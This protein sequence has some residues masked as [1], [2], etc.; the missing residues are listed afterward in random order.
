MEA[1]SSRMVFLV[2]FVLSCRLGPAELKVRLTH[3]LKSTLAPR[4]IIA[5][6]H[7]PVILMQSKNIV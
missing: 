6:K 2:Q 4:R 3:T 7:I 5:D 1:M